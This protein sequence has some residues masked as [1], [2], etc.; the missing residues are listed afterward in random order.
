V[1]D[2]EDIMAETTIKIKVIRL[3]YNLNFSAFKIIA[4][5]PEAQPIIW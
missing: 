3:P 5:V 2:I 1:I 4:Q